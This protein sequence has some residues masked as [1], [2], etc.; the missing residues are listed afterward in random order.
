[1]SSGVCLIL[2]DDHDDLVKC[3]VYHLMRGCTSQ[4]LEEQY[5]V[6][7]TV[8][9][10]HP[11]Y[12]RTP[13]EIPTIIVE[14]ERELYLEHN[15]PAEVQDT[16]FEVLLMKMKQLK[17]DGNAVLTTSLASA[18]SKYHNA[19]TVLLKK[20]PNLVEEPEYLL[21]SWTHALSDTQRKRALEQLAIVFANCS[22]LYLKQS[23]AQ[24]ALYYA[25]MSTWCDADYLKARL[26]VGRCLVELGHLY[27]AQDVL[28]SLK[29]EKEAQQFSQVI[30]AL[31]KKITQLIEKYSSD[32]TTLKF[33]QRES[34]ELLYVG[35]I[36]LS[37]DR[38]RGRGYKARR[39]IAKGETL[40]IEKGFV[41]QNYENILNEYLS[42]MNKTPEVKALH[43]N[44]ISLREGSALSPLF[45][46]EPALTQII[47]NKYTFY[48]S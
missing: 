23:C 1:M 26:R 2:K 19:A 47:R 42:F 6:G 3:N 15:L 46:N 27:E 39:D 30:D 22:Y 35:P 32:S 7:Q 17:D 34:P 44:L 10:L 21:L 18:L 40:I 37:N 28:T 13:S 45:K 20:L 16:R 48:N 5:A 12:C 33:L 29:G 43:M 41:S 31:L 11:L 24:V 9:I 38:R 4:Q 14:D 36:K 8:L 25:K